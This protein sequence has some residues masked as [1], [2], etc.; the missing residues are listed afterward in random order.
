M[1]HPGYVH[2]PLQMFCPENG[3]CNYLALVNIYGMLILWIWAFSPPEFNKACML[4][5]LKI[6]LQRGV[7]A[8]QDPPSLRPCI[9]KLI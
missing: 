6:I 1:S 8:P 9:I 4:F 7:T 2:S 5:T 3:V